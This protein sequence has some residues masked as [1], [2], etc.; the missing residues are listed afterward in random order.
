MKK[1]ALLA[2]TL[3][4][5]FLVAACGQKGPLYVESQV[6]DG[7]VPTVETPEINQTADQKETTK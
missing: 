5:L 3:A 1:N 7:E 6:K 2:T 4:T